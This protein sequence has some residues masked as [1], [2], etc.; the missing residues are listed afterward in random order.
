M[1]LYEH[2]RRVLRVT[3][4]DRLGQ[5][6]SGERVRVAGLV[7]CRQAPR[8]AKG[9]LFLTLEDECGLVNIIVRPAV[10]EQYQQTLRQVPVLLIDGRLQH[11]DGTTSVL[12]EEVR[13]LSSPVRGFVESS[14]QVLARSHDFH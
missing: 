9:F 11:E 10:R 4:A 2:Q 14:A 13:P 3:R 1:E 8:T 7:V 5:R 6:R 12:A